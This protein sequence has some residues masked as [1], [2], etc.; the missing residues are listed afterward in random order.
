MADKENNA[1]GVD[2]RRIRRKGSN[3]RSSDMLKGFTELETAE[4]NQRKNSYISKT[5]DYK[6][7]YDKQIKQLEHAPFDHDRKSRAISRP[8]PVL[9]E[10]LA[11]VDLGAPEENTDKKEK[12]TIAKNLR[13]KKRSKFKSLQKEK[14]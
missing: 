11:R 14:K 13:A 10:K 2:P 1:D 8:I 9:K 7:E 12:V 4:Y 3:Q 6:K 5:K